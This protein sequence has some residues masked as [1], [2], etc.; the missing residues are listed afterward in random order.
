VISLDALAS[1]NQLK[2]SLARKAH[3]AFSGKPGEARTNAILDD[4]WQKIGF[5][6]EGVK[7]DV[8]CFYRSAD[9]PKGLI[10]FC[11]GLKTCAASYKET[12]EYL[13][14]RGY[15][16]VI[17][18]FPFPEKY[19]GHETDFFDDFRR[20]QQAFYGDPNSPI[21][22]IAKEEKLPVHVMTHSTGGLVFNELMHERGSGFAPFVQSETMG[23]THISPFFTAAG[24]CPRPTQKFNAAGRRFGSDSWAR[25]I[26]LTHAMTNKK[27]IYGDHFIELGYAMLNQ[28]RRM[29]E[30]MSTKVIPRYQEIL[31][32]MKHGEKLYQDIERDS[33]LNFCPQYSNFVL[34]KND[35]NSCAS[36]SKRLG[37]MINADIIE[38]DGGLHDPIK[39]NPELID[40]LLSLMEE[41][42]IQFQERRSHFLIQ[43]RPFARHRH[44]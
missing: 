18:N 27:T 19:D 5:S 29:E 35:P 28:N 12:I 3:Q 16:V 10:A 44:L 26:F 34:G 31:T 25:L 30:V 15:S 21:Y 8:N 33:P 11:G 14:E 42:V 4:S 9:N 17:T 20:V 38:V 24:T 39:N 13:N 36:F 32:L 40:H 6:P 1:L 23:A 43:Q 22:R 41:D 7:E 37:E 2:I